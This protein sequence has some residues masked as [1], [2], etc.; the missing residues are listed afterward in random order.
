MQKLL[1]YSYFLNLTMGGINDVPAD[2]LISSLAEELKKKESIKPPEWAP[3]VKTGVHK[4]RTPENPD[5][6]YV[7]S[8]AV[9]RSIMLKKIVGVNRLRTKYGGKERRGV[10]PAVFK[11]G[12][13]SV[14]RK[15]VQ[16]LEKAGLLTQ[17]QKGK[18]GRVIT[19]EGMK[20]IDSAA[21]KVKV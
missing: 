4:E 8:A 11:K 13:G 20:L 7:R 9:L 12:S 5:W 15:V 1:K 3:Y 21:K 6:W 17:N 2:A 16:Q 18:K 10:K 14:I 19:P